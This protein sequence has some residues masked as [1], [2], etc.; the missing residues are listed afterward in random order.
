MNDH[1]ETRRRLHLALYFMLLASAACTLLFTKQLWEG[2]GA[3]NLPLLAPLLA[4]LAFVAFLAIYTADRWI[5]IRK[6]RYPVLRAAVQVAMALVF[7]TWLAETQTN[8]FQLASEQQAKPTATSSLL[9]HREARVRAATCELMALRG[10][11]KAYEH[12]EGLA[13]GDRSEQ[14]RSR[15]TEALETLK[16]RNLPSAAVPAPATTPTDSNQ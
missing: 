2:F 9:K 1:Q 14:V 13:L 8:Q 3:G 11:Q 6:H 10:E 16:A 12:I 4:P 7:L 15:C 5:L